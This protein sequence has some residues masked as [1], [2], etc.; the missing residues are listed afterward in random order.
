MPAGVAK[1]GLSDVELL[2][3]RVGG[4]WQDRRPAREIAPGVYGADFTP[5]PPGVYHV[6]IACDSIG[7]PLNESIG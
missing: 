2:M 3:Y 5:G 4:G 7:L 1:A 6:F